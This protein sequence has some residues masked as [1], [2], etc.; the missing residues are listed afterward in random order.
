MERKLAGTE[1]TPV[2]AQVAP[3]PPQVAVAGNELRIYVESPPL[4][5]QMVEDIR[6][7]QRRVWLEVYIF[8]ADAAGQAVADALCERARA[9]VD[10]RVLYDAIGSQTTPGWFFRQMR[11]AGVRVHCFHSLWEALTSFGKRRAESGKQRANHSPALRFPP[12]V[13]RSCLALCS[14]LSALRFLNRRNH[15]KLLVIDDAIAYFGGMNLVDQAQ[16]G[17][18][19]ETDQLP[20]SSG[21][22]DV[23][24]RLHGPKQAEVAESFYR[25]WRRALHRKIKRRPRPYRQALLAIGEESIQF[26]DSG[27]GL[28]HTRAARVFARLLMAARRKITLS[29]AYFLPVGAVLAKLLRAA[30]RG[31]QIRMV[32]P[33]QSDV[34]LV[35]HATRYL[36]AKL[37]RRRMR[38]YER[39]VNMLHS[40]VMV[41]DDEWTVIGSCNLDARSLYINLEFLAVIHSREMARQ[42][43]A[44]IAYEIER[45]RRITRNAVARRSCWQRLIDRAAWTFRWWL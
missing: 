21:W 26:F 19:Q 7:A 9:G 14:P 38:I 6:Q 39:Q 17:T 22:R 11:D 15:R 32:V 3:F 34:P 4:I 44:V 40:K 5:A 41:V 43:N 42:M 31:V 18:V 2:P 27:P 12:S 28:K 20:L 33:G 36:Y 24:V 13:V 1:G 37:L 23:H 25:S 8:L 35:Q 16:A 10:V 45:S 29:M 30:R